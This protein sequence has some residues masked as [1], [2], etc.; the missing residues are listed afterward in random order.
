VGTI[1]R[2]AGA[3]GANGGASATDAAADVNAAP[4]TSASKLWAKTGAA[5]V[6]IGTAPGSGMI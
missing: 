2:D 1:G 6:T 5:F 3:G 4:M